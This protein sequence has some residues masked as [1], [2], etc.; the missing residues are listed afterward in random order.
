MDFVPDGSGRVIE[1]WRPYA[2]YTKPVPKPTWLGDPPID[3]IRCLAAD[4][5][6]YDYELDNGHLNIGRWIDQAAKKAGR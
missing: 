4:A 1:Q 2:D 3:Y 6:E 5:V